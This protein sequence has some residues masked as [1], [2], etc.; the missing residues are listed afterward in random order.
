MILHSQKERK[1]KGR[2]GMPGSRSRHATLRKASKELLFS[3]LLLNIL[4]NFPPVSAVCITMC[5]PPPLNWQGVKRLPTLTAP[6]TRQ[7]EL[8]VCS[9][10][11]LEIRCRSPREMQADI[12][13]CP[14]QQ[15]SMS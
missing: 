12:H 4:D 13:Q 1:K 3:S 7:D 10:H 11:S 2:E 8:W 9:H 15:R 6:V 5:H 14:N